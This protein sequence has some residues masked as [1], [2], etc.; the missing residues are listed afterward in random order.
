MIYG[1]RT[2]MDE[3]TVST[4]SYLH[5]LEFPHVYDSYDTLYTCMFN[6][7]SYHGTVLI[8]V[9]FEKKN[10]IQNMIIQASSLVDLEKLALL[11]I[12]H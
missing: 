3:I 12:C 7:I 10:C 11:S 2:D 8:L 4:I 9:L 5:L 6:I 1:S